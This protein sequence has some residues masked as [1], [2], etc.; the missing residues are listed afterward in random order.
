MKKSIVYIDGFNLYYGSV[1][2]TPWKWLNLEKYFSLLRQDDDIQSIKY[3]TALVWDSHKINQA[4]YLSALD[5]LPKVRII[6]GRFKNKAIQ[7]R[8]K[9]CQHKGSRFFQM[10]E[11]KHT[12]VNIGINMLHDA[13]FDECERL[14]LVS[15]DSDLAPAISM[16]KKLTPQKEIFVYIPANNP[17][18]GY[19]TEIRGL[20][21]KSRTLPNALFSKAQFPHSIRDGNNQPIIKPVGW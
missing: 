6:L 2:G 12:D 8:V 11:E 15:G 13:V 7:C 17:Q 3:F 14:V 16:I 18:R 21:D 1:R 20:A 5:T 9:Q 10:P 19:A 4:V